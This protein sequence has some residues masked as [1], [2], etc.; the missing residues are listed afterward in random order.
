MDNQTQCSAQARCNHLSHSKMSSGKCIPPVGTSC[1]FFRRFSLDLTRRCLSK[2][3][4]RSDQRRFKNR[5][6]LPGRISL[7][8]T[9]PPTYTHKCI[10]SLFSA[11]APS[12]IFLSG[13]VSF[14]PLCAEYN[15]SRTYMNVLSVF[16][17]KNLSCISHCHGALPFGQLFWPFK[18][19]VSLIITNTT[20]KPRYNTKLYLDTIAK[21]KIYRNLKSISKA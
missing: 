21:C 3:R 20:F 2:D 13:N 14:K 19:F 4:V 10:I 8:Q 18:H 15:E 7:S 5:L 12:L 1:R 17:L 6:Q 9:C 16:R 11:P